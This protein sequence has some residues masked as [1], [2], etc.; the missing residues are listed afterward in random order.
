VQADWLS[1]HRLC[2]LLVQRA[3]SSLIGR[4]SG[5]L[6]EST[7]STMH[8]VQRS[9]WTLCDVRQTAAHRRPIVHR[10]CCL[11]V[12]HVS[13][14]SDWSIILHAA[15][16]SDNEAGSWSAQCA[17]SLSPIG[18]ARIVLFSDWSTIG[19]AARISEND[20]E[21][22]SVQWTHGFLQN[23]AARPFV[24][25]VRNFQRTFSSTV[26]V[27]RSNHNWAIIGVKLLKNSPKISGWSDFNQI[28]TKCR[29]GQDRC[30]G[31]SSAGRER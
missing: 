22:C 1:V 13:P 14:F 21:R 18:W 4:S 6:H 11:L 24:G 12:Q 23:A 30:S 8:V 31:V 2:R 26:A 17:S 28:W 20:D 16:I 3:S 15:R 9:G 25:S 7:T 19:H 5:T 29:P 10:P 27:Y